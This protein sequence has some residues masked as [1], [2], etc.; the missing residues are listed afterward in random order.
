MSL[1]MQQSGGGGGHAHALALRQSIIA[2]ADPGLRALG[3]ICSATINAFPQNPAPV[4]AAPVVSADDNEDEGEA[5]ESMD[6]SDFGIVFGSPQ[7]Q[8]T[9]G[10]LPQPPSFS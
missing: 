1:G 2:A 8:G 3:S 9:I 10:R 5:E 7:P 6:F 4:P